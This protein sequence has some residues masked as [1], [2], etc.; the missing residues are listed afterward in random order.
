MG[1]F[2]RKANGRMGR[3]CRPGQP[4][5]DGTRGKTVRA[6]SRL[7]QTAR[8]ARH[9]AGGCSGVC[10]LIHHLATFGSMKE[11][12]RGRRE[13]RAGGAECFDSVFWIQYN[14]IGTGDPGSSN[15]RTSE[16]G[17]EYWGSNPCPGTRYLN[18]RRLLLSGN[19]VSGK[20]LG[21][22]GM[23]RTAATAR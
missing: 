9:T 19:N 23:R 6:V 2:R 17:S 16:F 22:V 20:G 18:K 10:N 7:Y 5:V 21:K 15:G 1:R 12:V 13:R 11:G 3:S 4:T 8:C 14:C